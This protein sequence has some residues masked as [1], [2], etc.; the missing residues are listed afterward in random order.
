MPI[1][2]PL[3]SRHRYAASLLAMVLLVLGGLIPLTAS[4]AHA[5]QNPGVKV[6]FDPL[7]LLFCVKVF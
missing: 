3:L 1:Q 5:Q 2:L 7:T 4:T 6:T